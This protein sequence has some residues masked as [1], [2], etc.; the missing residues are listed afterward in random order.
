[1]QKH[2]SCIKSESNIKEILNKKR[3]NACRNAPPLKR[4]KH[5][6][7]ESI[8]ENTEVDL[9]EFLLLKMQSSGGA[10]EN[11]VENK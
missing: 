10:E 3:A 1:M 7:N 9:N 5:N 6:E 4:R 2:T 11:P 8:E